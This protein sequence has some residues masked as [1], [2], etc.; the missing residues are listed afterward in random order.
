MFFSNQGILTSVFLSLVD[1][2]ISGCVFI[3]S[4]HYQLSVTNQKH[5]VFLYIDQILSGLEG[6][7]VIMTGA[8]LNI[9]V[10]MDVL[11]VIF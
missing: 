2:H 1:L 11:P 6:T 9:P 10:K 5:A 3:Q 7:P 4:Q 8:L